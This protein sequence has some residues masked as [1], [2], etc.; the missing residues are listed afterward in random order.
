MSENV[1]PTSSSCRGC[2]SLRLSSLDIRP[3]CHSGF[4]SCCCSGPVVPPV[5]CCSGPVVAPVLLLLRSCCCSGPI[6]APVLLLLR[7]YCCSGS[8]VAPVSTLV[9]TPDTFQALSN[10]ES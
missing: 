10:L 6:V 1:L 2:I 4:R 3:C 5:C 8:V 9:S 7:S